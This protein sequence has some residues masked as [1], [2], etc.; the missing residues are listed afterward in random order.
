VPRVCGGGRDAAAEGGVIRVVIMKRAKRGWLV[1][2]SGNVLVIIAP[3]DDVYA[4]LV[5]ATANGPATLR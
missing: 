2:S 5:E 3:G 4:V 1:D